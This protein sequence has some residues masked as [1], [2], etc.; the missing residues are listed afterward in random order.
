MRNTVCIDDYKTVMMQNLFAAWKLAQE[1]IRKAQ[2]K[3][4]KQRAGST[5]VNPGDRVFV[6]MPAIRAGPAYKLTRPY[7]GPYRV[8]GTHP[9]GVELR[10]I[11]NPK[12]STIRVA[13]NRVRHCPD[14]LTNNVDVAEGPAIAEGD[15]K[16]PEDAGDSSGEVCDGGVVNKERG[17]AHDQPETVWTNR[18]RPR[19]PRT[20]SS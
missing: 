16:K 12:N 13:L 17:E 8:I 10:S 4:K 7:K 5:S 9:N 18:L 6:Y 15:T 19:N 3:Q 1:G 11:D 2:S 14:T 20:A